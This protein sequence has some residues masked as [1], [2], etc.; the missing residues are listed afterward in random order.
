M[1]RCSSVWRKRASI[2]ASA[3][4]WLMKPSKLEPPSTDDGSRTAAAARRRRR[5][6]PSWLGA[7]F[8]GGCARPPRWTAV[9][10]PQPICR[11][12]VQGGRGDGAP[13]ASS[14]PRCRGAQQW[15]RRCGIFLDSDDRAQLSKRALRRRAL[16]QV[17]RVKPPCFLTQSRGVLRRPTRPDRGSPTAV[18]ARP[19]RRRRA[20]PPQNASRRRWR[21]AGAAL[22]TR[23]AAPPRGR[24]PGPPENAAPKTGS[25]RGSSSSRRSRR[26]AAH[27]PGA[28]AGADAADRATSA[29]PPIPPRPPPTCATRPAS[30][31]CA[32]QRVAALPEIPD[33]RR[34]RRAA[35]PAPTTA[36]A[37][38]SSRQGGARG[39]GRRR[40][41]RRPIP[42]RPAPPPRPPS[43][44]RRPRL[45][46]VHE[47]D[48]LHL[49]GGSPSGAA[50][51]GSPTRPRIVSRS[52]RRRG[53]GVR[54]PPRHRRA[55]AG[56]DWWHRRGCVGR[57]LVAAELFVEEL[58]VLVGARDVRALAGLVVDWRMN[59]RMLMALDVARQD[60]RANFL[61]LQAFVDPD[62]AYALRPRRARTW[63]PI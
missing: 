25:P 44:R 51:G 57:R 8:G 9:E 55:A 53:G 63:V 28:E 2:A 24:A 20:A 56:F 14:R 18:D 61:A 15:A 11:S 49:V 21:G 50:P 33:H 54:A 12:Q 3:L 1:S 59:D 45:D 4:Q 48:L 30:A 5:I 7:A 43:R 6:R 32:E 26:D 58:E 40:R 46:A 38:A 10:A 19:D 42:P 41:R 37:R 47:R 29:S 17:R 16:V 13:R 36:P 34:R 39:A 62:G 60:S 52:G 22:D 27:Q 35:P 31:G 23:R